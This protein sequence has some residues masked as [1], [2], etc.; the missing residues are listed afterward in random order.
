M[1][2]P[3][4]PAAS[5]PRRS[6]SS[7]STNTAAP[8]RPVAARTRSRA[9]GSSR[10]R[11]RSSS[12]AASR[13]SISPV[14]RFAWS[15][16][17]RSA[18]PSREGQYDVVATVVGGGLSGQAGAVK[19]GICPGADPLR[20]GAPHCRQA[21]RVPD[22]RPARRRAQEIRPRQ[23]PPQLPVLEA[24]GFAITGHC[25]GRSGSPAAFSFGRRSGLGAFECLVPSLER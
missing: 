25:K 13:K 6:A 14:R 1:R 8:T 5:R 24:L 18:S 16:T 3:P 7:S 20:A 15:S 22:P 4:L 10:A 11:A 19:H 12:T 21:G 17:S 9:C 2:P 23:G